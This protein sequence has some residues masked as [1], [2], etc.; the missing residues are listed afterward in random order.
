M[1]ELMERTCFESLAS[2]ANHVILNL[3]KLSSHGQRDGRS[4]GLRLAAGKQVGKIFQ[5]KIYLKGVKRSLVPLGCVVKRLKLRLKW[6]DDVC[7]LLAKSDLEPTIKTSDRYN[8]LLRSMT[9]L[10]IEPEADVLR[11]L[12]GPVDVSPGL[13]D[14]EV[15]EVHESN[16]AM[17]ADGSGPQHESYAQLFETAEE[18]DNQDEQ[19][20]EQPTA[21]YD[22]G[23]FE[24]ESGTTI[25]PVDQWIHE[26][27]DVLQDEYGFGTGWSLIWRLK[28]CRPENKLSASRAEAF[29]LEETRVR[30]QRIQHFQ[31]EEAVL[32][33]KTRS[34][35]QQQYKQG[36][37][38][39]T[40]KIA[41]YQRLHL[42]TTRESHQ[43]K[44]KSE[45]A[46]Q[47]EKEIE[48]LR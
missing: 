19:K 5:G 21:E 15:V 22:G 3:S 44:I 8:V 37:D 26:N 18:E 10:K 34:E 47:Y 13:Q 38:R 41:E 20:E 42:K 24:A 33:N 39:N 30:N 23:N 2:S 40:E 32:V 31:Q 27:A 1:K 43:W 4:I 48:S 29:A 16:A 9:F 17:A 14:K 25:P 12:E 6:H 36:L 45:R 28:W 46:S 11:L 7:K 35:M